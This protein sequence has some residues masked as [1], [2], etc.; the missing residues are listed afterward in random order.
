[1]KPIYFTQHARIRI[2][3]R[4]VC[5]EEVIKAIREGKWQKAEKGRL[6]TSIEVPFKGEH[7]G[8]YYETKQIN[9]IF[10]EEG[11]RIVVITV[12]TFYSQ[13]RTGK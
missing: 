10:V 12:Y 5:E 1:M 13:R 11:N 9:P 3:E 7:Y 6:M 2:A 4:G 8:R